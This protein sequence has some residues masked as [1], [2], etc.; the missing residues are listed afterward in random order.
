M[1]RTQRLSALGTARIAF[2]GMQGF[3]AETA[4]YEQF[5]NRLRNGVRSFA[6]EDDVVHLA[7]EIVSFAPADCDHE[8][9]KVLVLLALC[10]LVA[11]RQGNTFLPLSAGKGDLA[12]YA[13]ALMSAD[14]DDAMNPYPSAELNTLVSRLP[15]HVRETLVGTVGEYK[16]LLLDAGGL[17]LERML[18]L[19]NRFCERLRLFAGKPS[20]MFSRDAVEDALSRTG[21]GPVSLTDEQKNALVVALTHRVSIISGG[22]GTGKTSIVVSLLRVAQQ[23][24]VVPGDVVL[25]AP[26][27]KAA[28]RM[29]ESIRGKNNSVLHDGSLPASG[30]ALTL[31]RLLR[32]SPSRDDFMHNEWNPLPGR[33]FVVDE[34]SMIDLFL[35]E[36]LISALPED[37]LL[38]LLGDADQLPSVDAGAVLAELIQFGQQC[39]GALSLGIV[40]L[41]E[42]FRMRADDRAGRQISMLADAVRRG[43]A[44]ELWSS[45]DPLLQPCRSAQECSFSGAAFLDASMSDNIL[46]D[47]CDAWY[48]TMIMG[49]PDFRTL[50]SKRHYY[51][52]DG[53]S[54]TSLRDISRLFAHFEAFRILCVTNVYA[55]GSDAV[56]RVF[57][58][59]AL[60][61]EGFDRPVEFAP[62]EPV[63]MER[64]DYTRSIFNGDQGIV[65]RVALRKGELRLM[66]V[67]RR[68]DGYVA[69]PLD[70]LRGSL[71][72]SY[73]VSV[74][75]SQG[76][77]YTTIALVL[78]GQEMRM[79]TQEVLYTAITRA[80][81][82]VLVIGQ[83]DVFLKGIQTRIQRACGIGRRL[84]QSGS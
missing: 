41:S 39:P 16:P 45:S 56:N 49:L 55:T 32:Y 6:M 26:T 68:G 14:P 7:A 23:L 34:A 77:E 69:Y 60:E 59:M 15:S 11:V 28:Q 57:H 51:G 29:N 84:Q 47:F 80:R 13:R 46:S 70:S 79:L 50:V 12:E 72:L 21:D 3:P 4:D 38:V 81:K 44:G 58:A 66:A 5:L 35:M 27:G 18:R 82:G 62:G 10:A 78:P 67:F 33:V 19:E 63:L 37:A 64:N 52:R 40:R 54:E 65:L 9:R 25:A 20:G 2:A 8:T 22:P 83:R 24:G 43:A 30:E 31:H 1:S 74:H 75:R 73:A 53:F 17:Y 61:R 71:S 42:S 36:R 48:R 76:S